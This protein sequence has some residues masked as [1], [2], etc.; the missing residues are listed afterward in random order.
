MQRL[1]IEFVIEGYDKWIPKRKVTWDEKKTQLK[2]AVI[3]ARL[4]LTYV[5]FPVPLAENISVLCPN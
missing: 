2:S 1:T 4:H 3:I 5:I